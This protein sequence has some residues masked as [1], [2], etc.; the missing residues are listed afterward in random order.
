MY[1]WK[2]RIVRGVVGPLNIYKRKRS[3]N[4]NTKAKANTIGKTTKE[5][6]NNN[7]NNNI[8]KEVFI[9]GN[10]KDDK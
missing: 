8:R 9:R 1:K 3:V 2:I 7:N 4:Q 6:N 10:S 5:N